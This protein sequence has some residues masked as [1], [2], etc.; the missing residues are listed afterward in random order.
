[1]KTG[2]IEDVPNGG[3]GWKS[4][5]ASMA[6]KGY[7]GPDYRMRPSLL[8]YWRGSIV[9]D[10]TGPFMEEVEDLLRLNLCYNWL[11]GDYGPIDDPTITRNNVFNLYEEIIGFRPHPWYITNKIMVGK[12]LKFWDHVIN[13]EKR[14]NPLMIKE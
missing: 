9:R 2:R 12:E 6:S 13:G 10:C 1:M 7:I 3:V 5:V 11:L 14:R 4:A 8:N